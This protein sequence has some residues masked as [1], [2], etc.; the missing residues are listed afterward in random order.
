VST[1]RSDGALDLRNIGRDPDVFEAFYRK[2]V[3]GV[4][5]FVARRV[6]DPHRAAD[7]TAEVFLAVIESSD[8]YRPGR[9]DPAAW[10][11]GVA[12]NVVSADRRRNA[13]EYRAYTRIAGRALAGDDD[14]A[15]IEERISA[16][17]EV[18]PLLHALDALPEHERAVMELVAIDGLSTTQAAQALGISRVAAAMRL[19]RGKRAMRQTVTPSVAR[20]IELSEE[21]QA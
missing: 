1:P 13:R 8:G 7:L 10:L 12:R 14:I 21:G 3:D 15:R 19:M 4:Q 11:Y 18:R 2:H 17:Q 5:R 16:E 6:T 20:T 9:G